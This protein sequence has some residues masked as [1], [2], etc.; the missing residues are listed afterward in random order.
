MERE[1]KEL[2]GCT[3]APKTSSKRKDQSPARDLTKFLQ[4]QQRFEEEKRLKQVRLKEMRE[5][6]ELRKNQA[7]K[8]N[9]KSK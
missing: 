2:E 8:V 3:F 9:N 7:S 4:D 1:A 5:M 6:D